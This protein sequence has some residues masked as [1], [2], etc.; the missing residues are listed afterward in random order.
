MVKY[1]VLIGIN[2]RN[3]SSELYGCINDVNNV[4]TFLQSQLGYTRFI[5]L[6]DD[7]PIKPTKTNILNVMNVLVRSLRPGDEAWFHYSGHGSLMI[8]R[9]RDEESGY[10]SS[11]API[12]Y[13]KTGLISDDIIRSN[14][15]Q[16]VPIGVKMYIV[17]DACHSGTGCDLRYKYDDSSYLI[18]QD[19]VPN[20]YV[21]SDWILRQTLREFKK[22]NK[23]PGEVYCISGCQDHQTSADAYIESEKM[24]GGALSSIMLSLLKSNDLRTYKWKHLLKDICCSEKTKGYT[25]QTAITSGN[26][27]NMENCVFNIS[28][29]SKPPTVKKGVEVVKTNLFQSN[30][31]YV[32]KNRNSSKKMIIT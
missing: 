12:D 2:Y 24:Y 17:L 6:T 21:P 31:M 15:V 13:E 29:P 18:N 5:T 7:T 14:L 8:D 4:K 10:D 11:I 23:I 25:Q 1:G 32:N 9:N 27:L 30:K 16:R 22:Y 28:V 19:S 26:P 3:T 20:T